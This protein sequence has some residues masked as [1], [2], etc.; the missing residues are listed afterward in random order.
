MATEDYNFLADYP[1]LKDG[2]VAIISRVSNRPDVPRIIGTGFFA[3]DKE[4]VLTNRH[5]AQAIWKMPK[6]KGDTTLIPAYVQIFKNVPGYGVVTFTLE[7]TTVAIPQLPDS[8][9]YA[10]ESP[11]IAVLRVPYYTLPDLKIEGKPKYVEG[12][13]IATSGFP[14]GEQLLVGDGKVVTQMNPT[15]RFG[16]LASMLPFPCDN[17]TGILV[18][19]HTQGGQSGSPI[20]DVATGKV[21]GLIYAGM[22]PISNIL[23][24]EGQNIERVPGVY[25]RQQ[26]GL[27]FCVTS[28]FMHGVV[29]HVTKQPEWGR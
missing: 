7:I 17:P 23:S 26:S 28:D 3:A 24:Q 20:F 2:V 12:M 16:K 9:L 5:V 25:F 10:S 11:D 18:D 21:I 15:L 27:T 4:I 22:D 13:E 8:G 19:T 29:S 6:L 14:L 1:K